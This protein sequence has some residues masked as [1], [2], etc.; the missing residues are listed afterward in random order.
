VT[1]EAPA[2]HSRSSADD[3]SSEDEGERLPGSY[4]STQVYHGSR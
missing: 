2:L 4:K 3:S 1:D